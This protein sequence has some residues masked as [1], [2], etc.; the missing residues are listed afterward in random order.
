MAGVTPSHRV[1]SGTE[2]AL[3]ESEPLI[4]PLSNWIVHKGLVY[5]LLLR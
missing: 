2:K 4:F 5:F 3:L 1:G